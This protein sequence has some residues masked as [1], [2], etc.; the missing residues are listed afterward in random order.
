MTTNL[1]VVELSDGHTRRIAV[2][3]VCPRFY[4]TGSPWRFLVYVHNG[5]SASL[6]VMEMI[7]T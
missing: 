2:F 1:I 4:W 6:L 3:T 5:V 7:P